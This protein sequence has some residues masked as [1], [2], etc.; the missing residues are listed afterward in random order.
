MNQPSSHLW[1]AG[2]LVLSVAVALA[3]QRVSAASRAALAGSTDAGEIAEFIV[4]AGA[5]PAMTHSTS[6]LPV[7]PFGPRQAAAEEFAVAS[8][9][10]APTLSSSSGR[11]LTAILIADDRRVAVIDERAVGVGTVLVDGSRV[12][13]IQSDRVHVVDKTGRWRTLTLNRGQ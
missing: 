13:S 6:N 4:P 12:A 7:D 11:R 5:V 2:L 8:G 3:A 1:N 10:G 9:Q